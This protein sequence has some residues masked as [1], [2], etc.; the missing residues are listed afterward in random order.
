M[1]RGLQCKFHPGHR[2]LTTDTILV[3]KTNNIF[4][5]F[6]SFHKTNPCIDQH[7]S[8]FVGCTIYICRS[9]MHPQYQHTPC[10]LFCDLCTK[11]F[12]VIQRAQVGWFIPIFLW[13]WKRVLQMVHGS[14]VDLFVVV[15]CVGPVTHR[16]SPDPYTAEKICLKDNMFVS[17]SYPFFFAIM[18]SLL[19]STKTLWFF[20]SVPSYCRIL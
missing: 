16:C 17:M 19:C 13:L 18:L 5:R 4:C 15:V 7:P 10:L 1:L 6:F 2:K 3:K 12:F 8:K 14:E 20:V 11:L 9:W